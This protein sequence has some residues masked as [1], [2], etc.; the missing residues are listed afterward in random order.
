MRRIA[1]IALPLLVAAP[2]IAQQ[3]VKPG[4]KSTAAITGG[5][6]A[7]DAGHTL[8]VIEH[9]LDVMKVADWIIDM[10]PEAGVG[11]GKVVAMGSPEAVAKVAESHTG[12]W[13]A[14]LLVRPR[15]VELTG[16]R[17]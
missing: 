2:V 8:I 3:M 4:S 11:G 14:P 5:T 15:A 17:D 13:L 6:Y 12:R 16:V 9:H 1:L 7:V 10:G